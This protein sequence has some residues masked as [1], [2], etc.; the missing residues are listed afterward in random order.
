MNLPQL[1]KTLPFK[2][3]GGVGMGFVGPKVPIPLLTSPLKGEEINCER[4]GI[5]GMNYN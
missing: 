1:H 5:P 2:G 3:R 4:L